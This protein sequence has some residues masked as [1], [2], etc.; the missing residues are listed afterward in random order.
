M[1]KIS[2]KNRSTGSEEMYPSDYGVSNTFKE[3][4][5]LGNAYVE[6]V[7]KKILY[8]AGEVTWSTDG[9]DST[10]RTARSPYVT[11][12]T[13]ME[14]SYLLT[15]L[16]HT[17]QEYFVTRFAIVLDKWG[18]YMHPLAVLTLD[19][20]NQYRGNHRAMVGTWCGDEIEALDYIPAPS[21]IPDYKDISVFLKFQEK[22]DST[23]YE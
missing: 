3:Y 14:N 13:E 11:L 9:D 19:D 10:E 7:V 6:S 18:Y 22:I 16:N 8:N 20:K 12:P 23:S 17:K 1:V 5:Y 15:F 21:E 2:R 4:C